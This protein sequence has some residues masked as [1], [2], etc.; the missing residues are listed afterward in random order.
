[1]SKRMSPLVSAITI[2]GQHGCLLNL[3][4]FS[5]DDRRVRK[6]YIWS[7]REPSEQKTHIWRLQWR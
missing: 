7:D 2:I 1:M 6:Q 3:V 4:P 5:N